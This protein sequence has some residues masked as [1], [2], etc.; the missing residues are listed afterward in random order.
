[1]MRSDLAE[2]HKPDLAVLDLLLAEGVLVRS[3]RATGRAV[4]VSL[5]NGQRPNQST[6]ADGTLAR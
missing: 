5:C 2:R 4:S 6:K 1:M 3:R